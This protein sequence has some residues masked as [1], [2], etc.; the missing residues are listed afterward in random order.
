[1]LTGASDGVVTCH[2]QKTSTSQTGEPLI[3]SP[4]GETS[5]SCNLTQG[6][7][8]LELLKLNGENL[9][10]GTQKTE[11]VSA[12]AL[13]SDRQAWSKCAV[14][15]PNLSCKIGVFWLFNT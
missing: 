2:W 9:S 7:V 15:L 14:K 4:D 8:R 13:G 5:A 1:M 10:N 12:Q 6:K 11:N 3:F